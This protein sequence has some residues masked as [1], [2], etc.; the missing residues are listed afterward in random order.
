[1]LE[2]FSKK[3][4]WT[5]FLIVIGLV[6]IVLNIWGIV[7]HKWSAIM[8]FVEIGLN[9]T[10]LEKLISKPD[11]LDYLLLI[12][13]TALMSAVPFFSS[14]V[15]CV[16]NGVIFG[17]ALGCMVNI[18]G[19][20]LGNVAVSLLMHK[21]DLQEKTKRMGN[22]VEDLSHYKNK[23]LGLT[24]GYMIPIIPSF[25]VNYTALQLKLSWKKLLPC[26]IIG[27]TPSSLLYAFGGH[28][29]ITGNIKQL[30]LI[31][32]VV[33]VLLILYRRFKKKKG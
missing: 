8:S 28:A 3:P 7:L 11:A 29:I 5:K 6:L 10:E 24:L 18:T 4:W 17:P 2:R 30:L 27:V 33:L 19:N 26:I 9:P 22:F 32:L 15:I 12:L 14:S 20:S 16:V 13:L 25:L 1:M 21:I 23:R 31:L